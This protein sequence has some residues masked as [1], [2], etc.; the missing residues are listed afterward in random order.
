MYSGPMYSGK[1]TALY[2]TYIESLKKNKTI[3][4]IKPK[5]DKRY[6]EESIVTHSK[7]EIPKEFVINLSLE[8]SKS[9]WK[10]I[11]FGADVFLI[12]EI[13]FF[14]SGIVDFIKRLLNVGKE[15]HVAGLDMDSKGNSFG[16]MPEIMI[17][18]NKVIKFEGI[19]KNCGILNATRTY[20]KLEIE[21][22]EQVLI[23]GEDIYE[24]R[25]YNCWKL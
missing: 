15:I 20:R 13:Q 1:S 25:C 8:L 22:K 17:L 14:D 21:N 12:D 24:C 9:E 5:I 23:G 18:A 16:S 7:K 11:N 19:C 3:L 10:D 4:A 6:S 2:N